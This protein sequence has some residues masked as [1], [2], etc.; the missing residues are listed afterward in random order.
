MEQSAERK[1]TTRPLADDLLRGADAIAKFLF[2]PQASR[3]KVYYLAA[4]TRIP[5]FRLGSTLCAR[6]SVLLE[7]ISSQESRARGE[8]TSQ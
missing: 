7:F 4:C 2:G 1:D 6:P 8:G 5:V 3:R